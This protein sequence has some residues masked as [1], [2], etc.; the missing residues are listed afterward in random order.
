MPYSVLSQFEILSFFCLTIWAFKMS[1]FQFW[2]LS[3]IEFWRFVRQ[4]DF[5]F[6]PNFF[7]TMR[8]FLFIYQVLEFCQYYFLD[9]FSLVIIQALAFFFCLKFFQHLYFSSVQHFSEKLNFC[10]HHNCFVSLLSLPS[11]LSLMSQ[12]SKLSLLS[13]L[14]HRRY[15]GR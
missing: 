8:F 11:P 15:I 3:Q 10:L 14:M 12:L 7:V 2:V 5:E 1:E 6:C 4:W 13:I 9:F